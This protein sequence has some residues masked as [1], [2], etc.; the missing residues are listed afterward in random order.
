MGTPIT[1][2]KSI[3]YVEDIAYKR[4][5]SEALLRK[6]GASA[7]YIQERIF[8]EIVF[9][10]HGYFSSS[11]LGTGAPILIERTADIT[12]Y[13]LGILDTGGAGSTA[14]NFKVYDASGTFLSNLFGSGVNRVL[15]SGSNGSNVLVGRD[16]EGETTN[17]VNT[18]G[19][20]IQYGTLNYTQ[21]TQGQLLVPFVESFARSARSFRFSL[22]MREL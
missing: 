19:H 5:L 18:S 21:L 16:V 17:A 14:V 3:F 15:I 4:A 13:H 11:K 10:Q 22:K 6:F 2:Q 1:P 9:E 7:N 20:T 8:N 12:S